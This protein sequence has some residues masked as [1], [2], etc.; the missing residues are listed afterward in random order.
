MYAEVELGLGL[1]ILNLA[2]PVE[3]WGLNID[4]FIW[5]AVLN[6][7][8]AGRNKRHSSTKLDTA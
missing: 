7:M 6:V 3:C 8:I 5:V 2:V 1:S 4:L